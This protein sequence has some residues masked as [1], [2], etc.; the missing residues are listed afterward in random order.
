M[1]YSSAVKIEVVSGSLKR[2]LV[3]PLTKAQPTLSAPFEFDTSVK[4]ERSSA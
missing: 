2:L 1:A 4:K 3:V